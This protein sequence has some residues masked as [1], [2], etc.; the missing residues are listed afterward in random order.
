MPRLRIA[1]ASENEREIIYRMRHTV[2]AGELGQHSSNPAGRLTD[3]LDEFNHYI[4]ATL[5]SEVAGFVSIT[6]PGHPSYSIDK[7]FSRSDLP[8]VF[9]A[10]LYEVR[11]LTVPTLKRGRGIAF[12]LMYAAQRWIESSGGT[13]IVAIGR[14]EIRDLYL[15]V[16]LQMLG[17]QVQ[18]G[19]VTYELM[20]ASTQHLR[21]WG[22][23]FAPVLQKLEKHTLWEL[24]IP[25]SEPEDCFHGGAFFEAVGVTFDALERSK[26][27]VNADVLDAWFPPAPG[28]LSA[29]QNHLPWLLQTSPPLDS[30]GLVQTISK[31]R[32]IP[33]ASIAV[34]AGSSSLIYLAFREWLT[35]N[36][37][38]LLIDPTYGEYAHIFEKVIG[39]QTDRLSL[40]HTDGY[41]I[42]L[43]ALLSRIQETPCDL[44]VL[45]NPNNPTG[46]LI[47]RSELELFLTKIPL[48]TRLWIDEAYIDYTGSHESVETAAAKSPNVIVCK[49][50]SKAYALSGARVAYLCGHPSLIQ[51]L[52][53]LTPPWAISLPAQ[54][55]AVAAL[56]DPDYYAQRY[57]ETA[58]LQK[59]LIASLKRAVPTMEILESVA[60]FIL[61][62]LPLDGPDAATVCE[63][64]R[65][66]DVFI[67]DISIM[68]SVFSPHTLRVAVKDAA[69]NQRMVEAFAAA[70]S[71]GKNSA[72]E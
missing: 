35:K 4:V 39:C 54:V 36:S 19:A 67:R 24:G 21:R 14:K 43:D 72:S 58:V 65:L 51:P 42:D 23:R 49:S 1:I 37:K 62:Y 27:V 61:C 11:L 64:C 63:S 44:V 12:V 34:G 41:R 17:L 9:D 52:R 18:S 50:L 68:S 22:A 10:G 38:V 60:N 6:P 55:G 66:H 70:I 25:Y 29:I 2:Y 16:G 59:A 15:K 45:V 31:T 3:S 5:D 32:G 71:A 53:R 30:K 33:A 57:A 20:S 48:G 40:S 8:F 13:R 7:Y 47:P 26:N 56:K 46:R 69:T 28:V